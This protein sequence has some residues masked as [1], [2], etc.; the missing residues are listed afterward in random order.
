MIGLRAAGAALT[1]LTLAGCAGG[2]SLLS[3]ETSPAPEVAMPGRWILS[4]PKA[5]VCGMMLSGNPGQPDGTIVPEGGCPERFF[6]SRHWS[7]QQG[8][9][10]IND[11]DNNLLATLRLTGDRFEGKSN[12][13]TPVTLAR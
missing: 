13:D 5:P 4:V 6:T 9:L 2:A 10:T 3:G 12:A 7:L 11:D 8:T 1:A